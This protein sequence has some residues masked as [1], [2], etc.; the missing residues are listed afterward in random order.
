MA[1]AETLAAVLRVLR[2]RALLSQEELA[3]RSG[4]SVSTVRAIESGRIGRP[5]LASVRRLADALA[6][7]GQDRLRLLSAAQRETTDADSPTANQRMVPAQLPAAVAGFSGREAALTTLDGTL[8]AN[9]SAPVVVSAIAGTAGIG[10]TALAVYWAHRV[11]DRFPDGQLYVNLRGFHSDGSPLDPAVALRTFLDALAVPPQRIPAELDAQVGLYRSLLAG[12]RVL[13]LLDNAR[14]ADQVRPLLPGAAGCLAVVTSR[15]QLTSLAVTEG[16]RLIALDLLGDA[17]AYQLLA[18]RVGMDR[19]AAEP[20]AVDEIIDRC[21]GLPLALA[22]VAAR[23]AARP[24][25]S[26]SRLASQLRRPD[27]VLDVLAG[28]DAGT[29][30]RTVFSWSYASLGSAAARLFRLLG[31]HPGP[32]LGAAA[33]ASLA[34]I[35]VPDANGL[36]AELITA[37]LAAEAHPGRYSLHDLLHAYAEELAD[38]TDPE[39]ERQAAIRRLLDHY[40]HTADAADRILNPGQVPLTLDPAAAGVALVR[41]DGHHEA[42]DWF[43]TEYPVLRAAVELANGLGFHWHAWQLVW[44]L[45]T[46]FELQTRWPDWVELGRVAVDS[47]QRSGDPMGQA[48]AHRSLGYAHFRVGDL[49]AA[50]DHLT[51]SVEMFSQHGDER[52]AGHGHRLLGQLY[53]QQGDLET[54]FEHVQRAR[55]LFRDSGHRAGYANTLNGLGWLHIQ[56]GDPRPALAYCEEAVAIYRELGSGMGEVQTLHSLGTAYHRLGQYPDAIASF[57]QALVLGRSLG[58]RPFEATTL[59]D[60]GDTYEAAGDRDA[61]RDAWSRAYAILRDLDHLDADRIEAKLDANP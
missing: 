25:E 40:R 32:D 58:Y 56:R 28:P 16:A 15:N 6:P 34:G 24:G 20:A 27:T 60:L 39:P 61:A 14:S 57:E 3:A 53:E 47:A 12:R 51:R 29:D 50:R 31:L 35:P 23:A 19:V 36:L 33:A 41:I 9:G 18:N 4:V 5:R 42:L 10:K 37:Q 38:A 13:V 22:V 7:A 46:F 55:E 49:E 54:A 8:T 52:G 30:L 48:H 17:E 1:V 26:L 2:E 45:G 59:A 21:A 43:T 44:F 11:A